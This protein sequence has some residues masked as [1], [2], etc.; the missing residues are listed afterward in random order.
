MTDPYDLT[1]AEAAS[2]IRLKQLSPVE[3]MK[4][5]LA[6][7]RSLEPRLKIWV[8][9][10]EDA[11]LAAAERSQELL[12]LSGPQGPLHG[13]PVGVKDIYLTKG[14]RTTAGSP[15]FAD[16]VPDHDA[17]CVALLKR[18]G[19]IIMGKTV[20]TELA[21]HDPAPTVNPWNP[22]H[23]P[24]GSSSGSAVGVAARVF[25]A[26]LGSQTG[27][28]VL[29][30]AS[31]NGVVGFKPSFGRISR[32]G[33][34]PVAWSLDTAG[35]FTR[36]VQD[37]AILLGVL[38]GHDPKDPSSSRAPV[39]DYTG[40]V[41]AAAAPPRI[42]LLRDHFFDGADPEVTTH[43]EQIAQRL[44][45][46]GATVEETFTTS[47]FVTVLAA[48]RVL[49][50]VEAASVHE[51][52]FQA[53]PDDFGPKVRS[54]IEAGSLMPA[55]TYVQAL[56][57]RR[58]FRSDMQN[59]VKGFD[60]ILTPSTSTPA[61]R[62]LSTTG[63]PRFQ[64]PWTLCG[65]PTISL[66]SGLSASGLPLGIQLAS[67]PLAEVSLLAAARWCEQALDIAMSPPLTG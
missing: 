40:A 58:A 26:A 23:T 65:F 20:T 10:D 46:A 3:L 19:A 5:S 55:V 64:S 33:V 24:G 42:A 32:Y 16:F 35:Y 48:H 41:S 67:A 18:A 14:V 9:L 62:D 28:S 27:G 53:R 54:L 36:S 63:D 56:R 51:A 52:D 7:S 45:K 11:A 6:R 8:T 61:P 39:P 30:P 4:S 25:P 38:A 22:A 12:K 44:A 49:M 17:T 57:L 21:C 60:V 13:V 29:R 43:T 34:M 66:P 47:S 37:A 59:A 15:L 50:S 1:V 31:Y 2:H